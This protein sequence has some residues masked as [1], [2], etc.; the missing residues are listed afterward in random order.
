M[1]LYIIMLSCCDTIKFY[2][3]TCLHEQAIDYGKAARL[4]E[5]RPPIRIQGMIR[6]VLLCNGRSGF[7]LLSF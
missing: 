5:E 2:V 7:D 4:E 3:E 6:G 1:P